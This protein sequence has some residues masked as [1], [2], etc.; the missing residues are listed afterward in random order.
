[1]CCVFILLT[2]FLLLPWFKLQMDLDFEDVQGNAAFVNKLRTNIGYNLMKLFR[3]LIKHTGTESGC[4]D[5]LKVSQPNASIQPTTQPHLL[6]CEPASLKIP[7]YVL[8]S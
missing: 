7:L 3:D 6:C 5:W 8:A 2:F 4:V 1:M